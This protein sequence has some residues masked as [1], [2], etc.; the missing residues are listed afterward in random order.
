MG[1][2]WQKEIERVFTQTPPLSDEQIFQFLKEIGQ[3]YP[4][5]ADEASLVEDCYHAGYGGAECL[6]DIVTGGQSATKPK[7]VPAKVR[8]ELAEMNNWSKEPTEARYKEIIRLYPD[9]AE[10]KVG[11]G[12][13][14]LFLAQEGNDDASETAKMY[15]DEAYAQS[16]DS[17]EVNK[18]LGLYYYTKGEFD[19]AV[20]H[21]H[22]ALSLNNNK[23]DYLAAFVLIFTSFSLGKYEKV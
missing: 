18:S 7:G 20:F 13:Y 9:Y 21:L 14:F 16:P 6:D 23:V 3:K 22:K 5:H 8:R 11:L 17:I 2:V 10:A 15:L 1:S 4:H 12:M 19:K